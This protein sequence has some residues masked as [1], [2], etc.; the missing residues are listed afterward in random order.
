MKPCDISQEKEYRLQLSTGGA[1]LASVFENF[2]QKFP[3]VKSGKMAVTVAIFRGP[4]AMESTLVRWLGR[5]AGN[6]PAIEITLNNYGGWPPGTIGLRLQDPGVLRQLGS[7]FRVLEDFFPGNCWTPSQ[8]RLELGFEMS[9]DDFET[10]MAYYTRRRFHCVTRVEQ[11]ILID[12]SDRR[13]ALLGLRPAS[14][15]TKYEDNAI[16]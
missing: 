15:F 14:L 12:E 8:P 9:Q 16:A 1:K 13:L 2:R 4:E 5:I 10:A 11:L 6:K 3:G 7:R